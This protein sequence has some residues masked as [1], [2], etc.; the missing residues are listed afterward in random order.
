[1]DKTISKYKQIHENAYDLFM[2]RGGQDVWLYHLSVSAR[3][4]AKDWKKESEFQS[5]K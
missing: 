2:A 3:Q 4:A 5:Q 1:M